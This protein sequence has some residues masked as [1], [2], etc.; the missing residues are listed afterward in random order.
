M[1]VVAVVRFPHRAGSLSTPYQSI[2]RHMFMQPPSVRHGWASGGIGLVVPRSP[3]E[4]PVRSCQITQSKVTEA[5]DSFS[6]SSSAMALHLQAAF[7]QQVKAKCLPCS[8]SPGPSLPPAEERTNTGRLTREV[9]V[10]TQTRKCG[11]RERERLPSVLL[12]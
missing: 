10:L 8:G 4:E 9:R 7:I 6:V 11:A 2:P 3:V 1:V 12:A 5:L